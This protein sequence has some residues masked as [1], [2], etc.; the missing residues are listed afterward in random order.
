MPQHIT[1]LTNTVL[2]IAALAGTGFTT[3]RPTQDP[4]PPEPA[5]VET[6]FVCIVGIERTAEKPRILYDGN[7]EPFPFLPLIVSDVNQIGAI[8]PGQQLTV[9]SRVDRSTWNRRSAWLQVRVNDGND[10]TNPPSGWITMSRDEANL[11]IP[12]P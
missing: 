10:D 8:S 11:W 9:C 6:E 3:G 1:R 12:E 7:P 4:P 2:L 5:V